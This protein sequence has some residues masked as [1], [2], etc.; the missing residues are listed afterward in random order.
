MIL[1]ITIKMVLKISSG[2]FR[3]VRPEIRAPFAGTTPLTLGGFYL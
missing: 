1:R 3:F 2:F